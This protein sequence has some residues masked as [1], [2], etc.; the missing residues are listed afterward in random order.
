M[1]MKIIHPTPRTDINKVMTTA[2][3][4]L[5]PSPFAAIRDIKRVFSLLQTINRTA[6]VMMFIKM[7]SG[8]HQAADSKSVRPVA[9]DR[10]R[11]P[12]MNIMLLIAGRKNGTIFLIIL[13]SWAAGRGY[14]HPCQTH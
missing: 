1:L 2:G 7:Q 13:L 6:I 5:S 10:T 8:P 12:A 3:L 11:P 14:L 4:S 9:A